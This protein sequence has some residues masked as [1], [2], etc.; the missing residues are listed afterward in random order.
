MRATRPRTPTRA[1]VLALVSLALVVVSAGATAG[2][3]AAGGEQA[4]VGVTSR[5]I[6]VGVIAD[7]GSPIAPN[8]FGGVVDAMRGFAKYVNRNGGIA[9]RR[10]VL[11]V[12]D[13]KIDANEARNAVIKACSHDFALVGTAALFLTNV[14]DLVGCPDGRGRPTGIP[15]I[16]VI[17]TEVEHQCSPV[18]YPVFAPQIV[19]STRDRPKQTYQNTTGNLRYYR[20]LVGGDLHGVVLLPSDV[21]ATRNAAYAA[22]EANQKAGL[23]HVDEYVDWSELTPQ[24]AYVQPVR[25]LQDADANYAGTVLSY[26][27]MIAWMREAR[28]Q[29]V[30]GVKV[31]DCFI[32]CYDRRYAA[33]G[34]ADVEGTYVLLYFLPFEEADA[35]PEVA[36]FV[37]YTGRSNVDGFGA[38]AWA[39]AELFR[40]V[41]DAVAAKAPADGLTRAAVLDGLRAVHAF[42]AGGMLARIDVGAKRASPCFVVVQ[43][44]HGAWKRVAPRAPGTFDCRA[45]NVTTVRLDL[46]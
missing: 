34:R 22:Y 16:P 20:K 3:A 23:L 21:R 38:Q 42:D 35:N 40:Q 27:S 36:R 19:C 11:D 33:E 8:V 2:R 30:T 31:W 1:A 26:Q 41:V 5:E 28:V 14:E 15:D 10:L 24:S 18:S 9:G 17:T 25:S 13:S 45:G 39:G 32:T 4:E 29:G 6:R 12:Y 7:V 37:R 46:R 44:R 43:L